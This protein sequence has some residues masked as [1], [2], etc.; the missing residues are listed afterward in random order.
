[1]GVKEMPNIEL[2][3]PVDMMA[4]RIR[5]VNRWIKKE[6]AGELAAEVHDIIACVQR[7]YSAGLR[8]G[9]LD[10]EEIDV[11]QTVLRTVVDIWPSEKEDA[12]DERAWLMERLTAIDDELYRR[13]LR[14]CDR[15]NGTDFSAEWDL[16]W[17]HATRRFLL[18][19]LA[20]WRTSHAIVEGS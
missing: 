3:A 1:M 2:S 8:R 7:S 5:R 6:M 9:S 11:V 10:A 4:A 15:V 17:A 13:Y 20:A 16:A 19:S 12:A 18:D 14:L